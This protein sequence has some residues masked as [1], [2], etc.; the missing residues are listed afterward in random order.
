MNRAAIEM[1]LPAFMIVF[2]ASVEVWTFL[3]R[4]K[5]VRIL[6]ANSELGRK[7]RTVENAFRLMYGVLIL[8]TIV[9][10]Y[11]PDYYSMFSPIESLDHPM[12]NAAGILILKL[13]LAWVVVAQLTIN[14]WTYRI[15]TGIDEWS[16][17][18]LLLYSEKL[19][20]SGMLMMFFGFFITISSLVA[21]IVCAIGLVYFVHFYR[22]H[23]SIG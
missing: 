1:F 6:K 5:K 4:R 12:I 20:L 16:Y 14:R 21:I 15:N 11:F 17:H 10:A 18:R 22:V 2:F 9:Y 23:R 8:I 7:M 3:Q 13:S 19:I